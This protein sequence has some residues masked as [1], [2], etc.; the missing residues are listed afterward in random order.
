MQHCSLC[1]HRKSR[2]ASWIDSALFHA[3]AKPQLAMRC[4]C[5]PGSEKMI[6]CV[7]T[8]KFRA[9][10]RGQRIVV[11]TEKNV[12]HKLIEEMSREYVLTTPCTRRSCNCWP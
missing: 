4:H 7:S 8:F 6:V 2:L 3:V 12:A 5:W 9:A 11:H 1:V 10:Q